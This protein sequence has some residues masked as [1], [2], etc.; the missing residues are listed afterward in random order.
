MIVMVFCANVFSPLL[1][2][3]DAHKIPMERLFWCLAFPK[4]DPKLP[5]PG[6]KHRDVHRGE[7]ASFVG[8]LG[9][10]P[11]LRSSEEVFRMLLPEASYGPCVELVAESP[12]PSHPERKQDKGGE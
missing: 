12:L 9:N 7:L 8:I 3:V 6:S 1:N 10:I 5:P 4:Y 2:H 11:F